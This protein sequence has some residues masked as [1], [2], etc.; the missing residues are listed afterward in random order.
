MT[1][2]LPTSLRR[3]GFRAQ[4]VRSG[5]CKTCRGVRV[6]ASEFAPSPR[7]GCKNKDVAYGE[8]LLWSR[9]YQ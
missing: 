7:C 9:R 2:N 8:T 3:Q 4:R 1:R 6:S 5:V